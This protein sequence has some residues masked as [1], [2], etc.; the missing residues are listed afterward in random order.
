MEISGL[1][2]TG[3]T[4]VLSPLITGATVVGTTTVSGTT[5]TGTHGNFT[6]MTAANITGSTLITGT[7]IKMS[8][9][10][11]ATQTFAEDNAIVFAIA[12]G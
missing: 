3:S 8:G 10:T 12:L 5:V 2:I 7:T 1:I 4:K 11:V 6:N 9:D